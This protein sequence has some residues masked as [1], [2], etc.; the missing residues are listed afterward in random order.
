MKKVFLFTVIF[1]LGAFLFGIIIKK[2]DYG[3]VKSV[4]FAG[5]KIYDFTLVSKN[6]KKIYIKG[7]KAV[8]T[9]RKLS[10]INPYSYIESNSQKIH[11]LANES[12]LDKIKFKL[13]LINNVSIKSDDMRLETEILYVN[14]KNNI[15]YNNHFCKI[16]TSNNITIGKE[17]FINLKNETFKLK[18]VKTKLER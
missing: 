1:F 9:G 18:N 15:A 16:T 5:S 7:S 14:L 12:I 10:I 11:L 6:H 3:R 4:K 17:I 8:E 13:I 2:L